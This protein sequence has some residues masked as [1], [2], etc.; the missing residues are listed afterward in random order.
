MPTSSSL[1]VE[2]KSLPQR[3]EGC[4]SEVVCQSSNVMK[5]G[6]RLFYVSHLQFEA[7]HLSSFNLTA[8]S[9]LPLYLPQI[10]KHGMFYTLWVLFF[11]SHVLCLHTLAA[12]HLFFISKLDTHALL[13][14]T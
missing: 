7:L 6:K 4:P 11:F 9:F 5:S 2:V 13:Y 8:F 12:A 14:R 10:F 1:C 3:K